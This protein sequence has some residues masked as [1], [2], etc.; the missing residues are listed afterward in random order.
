M[1]STAQIN[2]GVFGANRAI[3]AGFTA[4]LP[5]SG[6]FH[7]SAIIAAA[8]SGFPKKWLSAGISFRR[9]TRLVAC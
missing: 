8:A 7:V 6:M 9:R 4:L 2:C 3:P 1:S 5:A